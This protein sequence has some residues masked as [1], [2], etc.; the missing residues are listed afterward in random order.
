MFP[1][2]R[3]P[4]IRLKLPCTPPPAEGSRDREKVGAP[5]PEPGTGSREVGV[6]DW[7]LKGLAEPPEGRAGTLVF[8]GLRRSPAAGAGAL[9]WGQQLLRFRHLQPKD[10]N[11][12]GGNSP[13]SR[14]SPLAQPPLS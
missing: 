14:W 6:G 2:T 8:P 1:R 7:G 4:P 9:F 10:Q 13:L 5:H 12:P 3:E 11:S